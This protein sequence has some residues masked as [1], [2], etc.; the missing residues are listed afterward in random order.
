[1]TGGT[2]ELTGPVPVADGVA[3]R[4]WRDDDAPAVVAASNDPELARWIPVPRPYTL[5]DAEAYIANTR[6]WWRVGE[7]FVFCVDRGGVAVGSI[8]L[9]LDR[10]EAAI[11]Y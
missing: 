9:R 4:R 2:R 11:G 10:D 7:R 3:L 1:M 8:G 5:A 6:A